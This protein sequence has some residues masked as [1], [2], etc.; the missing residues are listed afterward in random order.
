[1][2]A[3][4]IVEQAVGRLVLL[5][6]LTLYPP[7]SLSVAIA[8]DADWH[9]IMFGYTKFLIKYLKSKQFPCMII[10]D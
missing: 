9:G 7:L 3:F 8:E 10:K 2:N 6:E 1:M 5:Q 4:R